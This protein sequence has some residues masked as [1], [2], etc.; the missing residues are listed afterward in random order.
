[1]KKSAPYTLDHLGTIQTVLR[2]C[3]FP[4]GKRKGQSRYRL[5]RRYR[6]PNCALLRSLMIEAETIA[7]MTMGWYRRN[8]LNLLKRETAIAVRTG[9]KW[10]QLAP[11]SHGPSPRGVVLDN[12]SRER[13][14]GLQKS[15]V[16]KSQSHEE[17]TLT[18]IFSDIGSK[19]HR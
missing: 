3:F 4:Q 8:K 16:F 2:K 14:K 10:P 19:M 5:D 7:K 11:P 1:M 9:K 12:T 18:N 6:L 17:R 15:P 13:Q